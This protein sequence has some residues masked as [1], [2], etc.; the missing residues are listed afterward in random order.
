MQGCASSGKPG[1]EA[2]P[3]LAEDRPAA[4][5]INME[6]RSSQVRAA[7]PVAR[8]PAKAV[9]ARAYAR[10]GTSFYQNGQLIRIQGL[11]EA[12]R[13]GE[14]AKQR[15]QQVL[16]R[17][18]LAVLPVG[19]SAGGEMVAVVRVNGRDVAQGLMY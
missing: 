2:K 1:A 14:H 9:P 19:Q 18:Q 11:D 5:Q 6:L 12:A 7:P 16:D 3:G 8:R 15:L 13:T 17:G 10:D 4:G